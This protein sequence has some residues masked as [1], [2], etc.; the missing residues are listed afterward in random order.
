MRPALEKPAGSDAARSQ[1]YLTSIA[2][3]ACLEFALTGIT[4]SCLPQFASTFQ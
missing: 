3:A 4:A 1:W 2:P